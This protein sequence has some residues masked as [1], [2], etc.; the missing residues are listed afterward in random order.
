MAE[1]KKVVKGIYNWTFMAIV[2]VAIILVNII[3]SFVYTRIDM[4]EDQRYSLADGTVDFLE[5]TQNF[6]S[7]LNI[8]IY[9]EGNLPAEIKHF[10]NAIED[11]L[12]EFK[13]YAGD[14]IEYQFINPQVGTEEEKRELFENIYAD[15]KGILPM[16]LLYMKDGSQ[17]KMMLWP[18]AVMEYN[19]STVST[20]QFLPGSRTSEPYQL[21]DVYSMIQNSVNNLEYML[22]S[23]IRKSTQEYRPRIGFLQGHGELEYK[24]TQRARGMI[25]P[26]FSIADVELKDSI[27][28][29]DNIDGLI[30][31]RPRTKFSEKDLY[32]IDQ[33]VMRGG[34]LM[35]FLD[36][37]ELPIDTLNATGS[38]HTTRYNVG[39][40][41]C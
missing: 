29:L 7:R 8:K 14:R 20:V 23:S 21:N 15:G 12:K 25:S 19:G 41:W 22:V 6:K 34:K 33:F 28:S 36:Q 24:D 27:G 18:G 17:T 38:T 2:I 39:T 4:T 10:R 13:Q 11:K 1:K 35:C 30:I 31:A 37:L 26:Y 9:L 40:M 32:L 3:S 16:D 5:N